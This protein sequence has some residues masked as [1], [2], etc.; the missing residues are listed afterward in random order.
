MFNLD[1]T[2]MSPDRFKRKEIRTLKQR[3]IMKHKDRTDDIPNCPSIEDIID[4]PIPNEIPPSD[5]T[6]T[7]N[8]ITDLSIS[9]AKL[10]NGTMQ[11]QTTYTAQ[12][13]STKSTGHETSVAPKRF[14]R[15]YRKR[16]RHSR[17]SSR[18]HR[19]NIDSSTSNSEFVIQSSASERR[20]DIS[21]CPNIQ[22]IC[23][24]N[25]SKIDDKISAHRFSHA[26]Y[27]L[28]DDFLLLL[29]KLIQ[30]LKDHPH[31]ATITGFIIASYL[32][33]SYLELS[34]AAFIE[35]IVQAIWP[36]LHAMLLFIGRLS[37]NFSSFM[38]S[39]DDVIKGAYCDM[40][41]IWCRHFQMMCA[42][43][44]SFFSMAVE[45]LRAN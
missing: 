3:W 14:H 15:N 18:R 38:H 35:L 19:S 32:F 23:N 34:I 43:Q 8:V 26:F 33:I 36:I 12:E 5:K 11:S 7:S 24:L 13:N 21:M 39:S 10:L 16:Q 25:Q 28:L 30:L 4:M 42:D 17:K 6:E 44:C 40:A 41:E 22:N 37:I 27:Q 1:S 2:A 20:D 29:T 9:N 45:R 31:P